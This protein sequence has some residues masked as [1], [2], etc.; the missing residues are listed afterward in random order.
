MPRMK[1]IVLGF[2]LSALSVFLVAL[3]GCGGPSS[4]GQDVKTPDEILAEQEAQAAEDEKKRAAHGDDYDDTVEK[5]EDEK[6]REWDETGAD[7]ALK[8]AARSAETCPGSVTEK[9]PKGTGTVTL[10][11]KNDG[12]V[13]SSEIA[14]PYSDTPVGECVL[15]AMGAVIVPSYTGPEK[16]VTWEVDLTGKGGEA[17]AEKPKEA[18]APKK[19]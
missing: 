11:F 4:E 17:T 15:R 18:P 3:A 14:P 16:Q 9:A 8:Q 7:R 1:R 6:Q 10:T 12:N 13:K 5:T 2:S 19:K